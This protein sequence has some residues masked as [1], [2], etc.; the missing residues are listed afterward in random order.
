MVAY[1]DSAAVLASTFL[2]TM[3]ANAPTAT[4]FA[5]GPHPQVLA[6]PAA[7]TVLAL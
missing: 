4:L 3:L 5:T 2:H 1:A 7:A 6:Y